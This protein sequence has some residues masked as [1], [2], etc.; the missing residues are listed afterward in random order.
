ML[1]TFL[2]QGVAAGA[3]GVE[4]ED[5]LLA[6]LGNGPV[7]GGCCG[8]GWGSEGGRGEGRISP[9]AGRG[10]TGASSTGGLTVP[11]PARAIIGTASRR[12]GITSKL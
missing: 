3:D 9:V 8:G 10:V 2:G 5:G 4:V 7:Q 11:H 1:A 6:G 12:R